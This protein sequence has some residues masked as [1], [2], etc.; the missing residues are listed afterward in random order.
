MNL[1][2]NEVSK[3][4]SKKPA[5]FTIDS[6]SKSQNLDINA[7]LRLYKQNSISKYVGT[8]TKYPK[9]GQKQIAKQLS[10][11]DSTIKRFRDQINMTRLYYRKNSVTKKLSS[12]ESSLISS[13]ANGSRC[14]NTDNFVN[15]NEFL[16]SKNLSVKAFNES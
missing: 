2:K 5:S 14:D 10:H 8:K 9:L 4:Y 13:K 16:S 3:L 6:A 15:E 7:V 1:K 11:S 12:E